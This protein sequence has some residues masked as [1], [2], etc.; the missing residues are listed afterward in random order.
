MNWDSLNESNSKVS[1]L[2]KDI[3]SI[4]ENTPFNVKRDLIQKYIRR[5]IISYWEKVGE[6]IIE[7]RFNVPVRPEEFLSQ[8]GKKIEKMGVEVEAM[9]FR[10]IEGIWYG[11]GF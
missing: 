8:R 9:G 10:E 2:R 6:H 1:E 3:D 5:I 4:R 11:N 7:I